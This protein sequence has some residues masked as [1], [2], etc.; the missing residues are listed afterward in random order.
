[1]THHGLLLS[2]G[3]VY[4]P[5][6]P[7]HRIELAK[8]LTQKL[9]ELGFKLSGDRTRD[10]G[11]EYGGVK[12]KE[13]VYVFQHR[14]DPGLEVQVFTSVTADGS[15]RAKG[16]DAIRV[17]LIYKNKAKQQGTE[18]EEAR[19]YDLGSA[20]RVHRTGEIDNI[21]ERTVERAREMYMAANLVERCQGCS[22]P[23]ATSKQGKKY[24]G[25][26]CWTKRPGYKPKASVVDAAVPLLRKQDV[27]NMAKKFL[28]DNELAA[29]ITEGLTS[30]SQWP[31]MSGWPKQ[32]WEAF[33]KKMAS[34]LKHTAADS[35]EVLEEVTA[36]AEGLSQQEVLALATKI[37]KNK[38]WAA[39]TLEKMLADKNWKF[40]K[41]WP[42]KTWADFITKNA[43]NYVHLL[44]KP[45]KEASAAAETYLLL[46]AAATS[47][48]N[49]TPER[50]VEQ[51]VSTLTAS[52]V[53]A[54]EIGKH[55]DLFGDE[56]TAIS[57][58]D[59]KMASP[60]DL[61]A[62]ARGG[63]LPHEED[64]EEMKELQE[65]ADNDGDV[66]A[67]LAL[68]MSRGLAEA[69]ADG[70]LDKLYEADEGGREA[71]I[72]AFV[73]HFR[74]QAESDI[75]YETE[76][77]GKES[78]FDA[79]Q[80]DLSG[81]ELS[82]IVDKVKE[83]LE[84]DEYPR[85][86]SVTDEM[87]S[88][89]LEDPDNYDFEINKDEY[90]RSNRAVWSGNLGT[91]HQERDGT[92]YDKD[93]EDLLQPLSEEDLVAAQKELGNDSPY[94]SFGSSWRSEKINKGYFKGSYS[95]T[96]GETESWRWEALADMTKITQALDEELGETEGPVADVEDV[97]YR[98]AGSNDTV[99]GASSK[100]IYVVRL[101]PSQLGAEG[102]ALGICVGRKDMPYCRR[103]KAGEIDLYS[104]R[105]ES[106]KQKFTIEI[107]KVSN[108][109]AQVKGKAN[110]VPGFA[111]GDT[112][113]FAKPDE[114]RL[115]TEFLLHLG[116]T[117]ARIKSA[118]DM[119][120]G[121]TAMEEAGQDP[122]SPPQIKKRGELAAST[123]L[124]AVR[125]MTRLLALKA[126]ARPWG[127]GVEAAAAGR[128][129]V[130]RS[131]VHYPD[132]EEWLNDLE[133]KEA[134]EAILKRIKRIKEE[135][136]FGDVSRNIRPGL[137]E[138]R[139]DVGPGYR[140]YYVDKVRGSKPTVVLL[141][142]G[143]KKS[144]DKDIKYALSLMGPASAVPSTPKAE[145][146][147]GKKKEFKDYGKE[148]MPKPMFANLSDEELMAA[149]VP[150]ARMSL[151][152]EIL[153]GDEDS[154][155]AL[156]DK[157]PFDAGTFLLEKAVSDKSS[158]VS[159]SIR[160]QCK[161]IEIKAKAL[162]I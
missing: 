75:Q 99:A 30:A 105:T 120:A 42:A 36:S 64:L 117:P 68:G 66:E 76:G 70:L 147:L 74:E 55:P 51:W 102:A 125:P 33:F 16:A 107:D 115:A 93:L 39:T 127:F 26:V 79:F 73:K 41:S 59:W 47:L 150:D 103:L 7:A 57:I 160:V 81:R 142:G 28:K 38:E 14:K 137:H 34:G 71:R 157:L 67:L 135:G 155:L 62:A 112:T 22:S 139:F 90:R 101:K 119:N 111:S 162:L 148:F 140:V 159:G 84:E 40:V 104:I 97:I 80:N 138:L 24:C 95:Y 108:T 37:L 96:I 43:Q 114:V 21:V 83:L 58:D 92:E 87:L 123:E 131:V 5:E 65:Q 129:A 85:L 149:G 143:D 1:M 4:D 100:G 151:V 15:V 54:V 35:E 136:F 152:R 154:L 116:F 145:E 89:I 118:Y 13:D 17:C 158:A 72:E 156:M 77:D 12:G 6:N 153:E 126:C 130:P 31:H 3:T 91:L 94:V 110:R 25:E 50:E 45:G 121:V 56:P 29:E 82:Y 133:D 109:I 88:T 49:G 78:Y 23:M 124:I 11:R 52:V 141:N 132:F 60:E 161:L 8:K 69:V 61:L 63:S 146:G 9:G 27:L 113:N 19:Q 106:G 128:A 144:Q 53:Q 18:S 2:A 46:Q 32:T 48:E 10:P 44:S 134:V 122:F 20:C 98:Y 86:D